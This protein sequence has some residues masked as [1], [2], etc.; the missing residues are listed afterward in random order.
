MAA[1]NEPKFEYVLLDGEGSRIGEPSQP[2]KNER[3]AADPAVPRVR[4]QPGAASLWRSSGTTTTFWSVS[5]RPNRQGKTAA[6][7]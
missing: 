2:V 5:V 3:D 6:R 4:R 7:L 1:L